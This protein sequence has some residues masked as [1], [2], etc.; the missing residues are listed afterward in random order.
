MLREGLS[1]IANH[2]RTMALTPLGRIN[3]NHIVNLDP[4][5]MH[6]NCAS[7]IGHPPNVMPSISLSRWY[8]VV[9]IVE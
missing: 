4:F 1:D 3:H 9:D 5:I 2:G 6:E 8:K 7:A